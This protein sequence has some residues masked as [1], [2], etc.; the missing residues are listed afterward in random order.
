MAVFEDNVLDEFISYLGNQKR[1]SNHTLLSYKNDLKELSA[2]LITEN[3][4]N[5]HDVSLKSLRKWISQFTELGMSP[6]SIKRKISSSKSFFRYLSKQGLVN[7]NPT[8][9]LIYKSKRTMLPV[10]V[11][12]FKMDQLLNNSKPDSHAEF[13]N[14][15]IVLTLYHTGIRRSELINLKLSDIDSSKKSIKVLGKRNKERIIPVLDEWLQ[16][17]NA[18]LDAYPNSSGFLFETKKGAKLNPSIVYRAVKSN[19][20]LVTTQPKKSPHVLRHSFATN[21]LENG[22]DLNAIKELLG[23][24]SL[25]AT[26]IYTKNSLEKLKKIHK[27]THPHG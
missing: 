26:Q 3:V 1:Y 4:N 18:F 21:M 10:F 5:F 16:A 22:A 11:E 20:N 12:S 17:M 2:F 6:A 14:L 13:L 27:L 7:P 24:S 8:I 25:S 9:G 23:H 19:L 15:L